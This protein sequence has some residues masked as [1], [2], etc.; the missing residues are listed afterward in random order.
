MPALLGPALLLAWA[1]ASVAVLERHRPELDGIN[2]FPVA[3]ADTG[4]N[5]LLTMRSAVEAAEAAGR[6]PRR[7]PRPWRAARSWARAATRG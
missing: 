5:L 6:A 4:T 3:D 2:V 7:S 1:R